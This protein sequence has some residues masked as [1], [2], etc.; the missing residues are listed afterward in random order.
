MSK[1]PGNCDPYVK[2]DDELEVGVGMGGVG[3][4]ERPKIPAICRP[5][6][7]SGGSDCLLIWPVVTN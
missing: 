5:G 3:W 1:Y 6:A 7:I 4:D 2:V